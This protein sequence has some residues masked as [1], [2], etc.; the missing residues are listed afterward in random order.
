[1]GLK[2]KKSEEDLFLGGEG[3]HALKLSGGPDMRIVPNSSS[4]SLNIRQGEFI[5]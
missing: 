1:M 3:P 5:L 4:I 2:V